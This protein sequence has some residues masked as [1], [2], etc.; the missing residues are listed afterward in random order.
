MPTL[1][2]VALAAQLGSLSCLAVAYFKRDAG[3]AEGAYFN[4]AIGEDAVALAFSSDVRP[5]LAGAIG[6]G[7]VSAGGVLIHA[8][9]D[10]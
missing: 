6:L 10:G 5:W 1:L 8:L 4:R 9:G 3:T 7:V 2:K